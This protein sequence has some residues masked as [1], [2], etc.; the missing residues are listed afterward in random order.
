MES[1]CA[2]TDQGALPVWDWIRSASPSPKK[3]R[4]ITKIVTR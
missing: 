4:A 2:K 1:P 3:K